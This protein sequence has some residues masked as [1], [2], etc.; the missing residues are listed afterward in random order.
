MAAPPVTQNGGKTWGSE[1]NQPTGQFYHANLDD[2]FPFHI[3]GAQQDRGS[4]E[5]P[6]AVAAE[7]HSAALE[8]T[9]KAAR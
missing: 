4:V 3:Y 5:A 6:S 7:G 1:S 9:Y 8:K 2:Q